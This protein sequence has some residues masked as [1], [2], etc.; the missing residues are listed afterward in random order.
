ME[1]DFISLFAV[2]SIAALCPILADRIPGK[3]IPETVFL[4]AAGALLG[5]YGAHLFDVGETLSFM[6]ELG[7]AFLFLLAGYEI[8]PR[9]L[10]GSQGRAGLGTW[11][12]SFVA[13][14][15]LTAAAPGVGLGSQ[16]GFTLAIVLTTTAIGT[17]IPI[18]KERQIMDTPVGESIVIYGT[19]GEVAP[20]IAIVLLLSAR[21]PWQSALIL[22]GMLALC[23]FV[24]W[25][26][27]SV[28]DRGARV[29]RI[30]E[31]RANTTSQSFVRL[32]I[33]LLILLVTVSAVFHIDAVLGAFAAGFTLR[34]IVPDGNHRLEHKLD[35]IGFGFFIPLFFVVSGSKIDLAAVFA[36]PVV[37]IV[38]IVALLI[39]RAVPI[40]MSAT[41]HPATRT[42]SIHARASVA[43]YC[44]TALPLIVAVTSLAV[45][46]GVLSQEMASSLV[47]AGAITV[48]LMPLVGQVAYEV[49]DA[50]E[51]HRISTGSAA[52]GGV[53]AGEAAASSQAAAGQL[54]GESA[55]AKP[56][57]AAP[58]DREAAVAATAATGAGAP[59]SAPAASRRGQRPAAGRVR[60]HVP[61][62]TRLALEREVYSDLPARGVAERIAQ[63][64][65]FAD[66]DARIDTVEQR[67]E[68][69]RRR[70]DMDLPS[71][72]FVPL[73]HR[74]RQ[75]RAKRD[76]HDGQGPTSDSG[77]GAVEGS[78][79]DRL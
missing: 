3:M 5:P 11:A 16:E 57:K 56:A 26:A 6:S 29:Y 48:F 74:G 35:G 50:R 62:A 22:I 17:L 19:W 69:F 27:T 2:V 70:H 59:S 24:A 1:V 25:R 46:A 23:V 66:D 18:L 60:P 73:T 13:A 78:G 68:Q 55:S 67:I 49:A 53:E 61:L 65:G 47:A 63:A 64:M 28:R 4:L 71:L 41:L 54:A 36:N 10:T 72:G 15:L 37:L 45:S 76:R 77:N 38:F 7:M 32:T 33:W 12:V 43:L 58:D 52:A 44:T 51:I 40:F 34:S 21:S 14:L 9:S 42:M 30:L 31:A 20:V 8:N 39:V 79:G 75:L